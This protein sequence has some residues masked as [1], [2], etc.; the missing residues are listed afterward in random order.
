MINRY[1]KLVFCTAT[2]AALAGCLFGAAVS[3]A[4]TIT[5]IP[6]SSYQAVYTTRL[7]GTSVEITRSL[8]TINEQYRLNLSASSLLV[9]F[10][11]TGVFEIDQQHI[12]PLQYTYQGTGLNRRKSSNEFDWDKGI[13]RSFYKDKWYPLDTQPGIYDRISWLEQ[14]R[15]E[16]ISGPPANARQISMVSGKRV[17]HYQIKYVGEEKLNTALGT[18]NALHFSRTRANSKDEFH[19]WLAK[20]W[21]YLLLQ[22]VQLDAYNKTTQISLKSAQ[23]NGHRVSALP[24]E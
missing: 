22:I 2:R 4:A 1:L 18:L 3:S 23:V 10:S 24:P 6:L 7:G 13:V 20:D 17:K 14:M 21:Q 19:I 8:E 9:G 5:D 16:L 15:L 12:K 11:E